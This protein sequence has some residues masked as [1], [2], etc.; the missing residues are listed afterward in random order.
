ML[1]Q[2]GAKIDYAE[3]YQRALPTYSDSELN[4]ALISFSPNILIT[5]SGETLHNLVK[6]SQNRHIKRNT[7]REITNLTVLVPSE[8]VAEQARSLG[9]NKILV[10]S[11]LDEHALIECLALNRSL[12]KES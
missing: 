1:E 8:R 6:L 5:L 10:P 11:A 12:S 7:K 2:R 4:K 9:F 3:L